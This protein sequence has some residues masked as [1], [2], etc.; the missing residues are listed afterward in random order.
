MSYSVPYPAPSQPAAGTIRNGRRLPIV[1]FAKDANETPSWDGTAMTQ[2][3]RVFLSS[4]GDVAD[5]RRQ[6]GEV[7]E[8]LNTTMNALI[9]ERDLRLD[10]VTW[11]THTF[12]D[13]GGSPQGVVDDQ[14]DP[15]NC[16]LFLGIMWYR[17]GTP[18]STAG[19][20]T[21]HEFRA[22]RLGWEDA[23]RPAH[24]MFYFCNAAIPAHIAGESADQLKAVYA[25]RTELAQHGLVGSYEDRSQFGDQLRRDLV[26]VLSR[27]LH[28][29][30]P[31][32][33]VAEEAATRVTDASL[34][35]VREQVG[36]ES[37]E[38]ERIRRSMSP[39]DQRTRRLE[40]V[41]SRLRALAQSVYPLLPELIR[42]EQPGHR[43]AAVC[44][45][46]AI[47]TA[48]YLEWLGERICVETPFV[49]YHAILG[50][51][52]AARILPE[53]HLPQVSTALSRAERCLSTLPKDTDRTV[54]LGYA[55]R[56]LA[57]RLR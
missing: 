29:K 2:R 12:P 45:L 9:P 5:E 49:G 52:E 35:I 51:L 43:L 36:G 24:I 11:E 20:G 37:R 55:Q 56:A 42:S 31:P 22:A 46:Q 19:S 4:P 41:A 30:Q 15:A 16:D 18:T 28:A 8:E 7:I 14:T 39:G 23:R 48:A 38:Y 34:A 27:L 17:F 25:F 10:L 32:A 54:T 40:V 1:G 3:I 44:A 21:E 57:Q 13:L 26:R 47:P 33:E 6:C 53:E 50:L